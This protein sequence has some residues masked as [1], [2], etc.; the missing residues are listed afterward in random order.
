M[1][2]SQVTQDFVDD[3]CSVLNL[4]EWPAAAMLLEYIA[5]MA[6][7]NIRDVDGVTT[8]RKEALKNK[9]DVVK[10]GKG[11]ERGR[12]GG[13]RRKGEGEREGG[14]ERGSESKK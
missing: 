9:T 14:R 7:G 1:M 13:E 4:P 10:K 3:L 5:K 11:K 6:V 8:L 12:K 2:L